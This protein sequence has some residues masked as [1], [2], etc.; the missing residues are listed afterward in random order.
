MFF[1]IKLITHVYIY[2]FNFYQ[3]NNGKP[4]SPEQYKIEKSK[5]TGMSP[6]INNIQLREKV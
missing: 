3:A 6:G 5:N 4:L 2:I 1:F